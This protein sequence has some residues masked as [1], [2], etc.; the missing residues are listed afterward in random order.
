[1]KNILA[2]PRLT[3]TTYYNNTYVA[4]GYQLSNVLLKI[5]QFTRNKKNVAKL[6]TN[7]AA[8]R[9]FNLKLKF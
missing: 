1:M 4:D 8:H 6:I 5:N 2:R 9:A 3:K 7:G